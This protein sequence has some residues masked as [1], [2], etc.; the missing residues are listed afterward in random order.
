VWSRRR[1]HI[2]DFCRISGSLWIFVDLRTSWAIWWHWIWHFSIESSSLS[3]WHFSI[4]RDPLRLT[5]TVPIGLAS[6][7]HCE[8]DP[9]VKSLVV[10]SQSAS[11]VRY[12]RVYHDSAEFPHLPKKNDFPHYT[13]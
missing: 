5:V 1:V 13:F 8:P 12:F 3:V 4:D 10:H 2:W 11:T 6:I 7:I 9:C